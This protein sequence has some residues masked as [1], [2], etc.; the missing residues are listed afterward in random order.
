RY[1]IFRTKKPMIRLARCGAE[2][3]LKQDGTPLSTSAMLAGKQVSGVEG[4]LERFERHRRIV[5]QKLLADS[6]ELSLGGHPPDLVKEGSLEIDPQPEIIHVFLH[7]LHLRSLPNLRRANGVIQCTHIFEYFKAPRNEQRLLTIALP[8][9]MEKPRVANCSTANHQPMRSSQ[10]HHLPRFGRRIHIPVRKYRAIEFRHRA[11]NEIVMDFAAVH[12]FDGS[13]M[14][15]QKIQ[16]MLRE[17]GQ[18]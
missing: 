8:Y 4:E 16:R 6:E 11:G 2:R 18:Q 12:L 13:T 1:P 17:D 5:A 3:F 10:F 9:L 14:N 7:P 15:G